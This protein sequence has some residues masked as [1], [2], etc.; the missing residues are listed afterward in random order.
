MVNYPIGGRLVRG[1]CG[2]GRPMAV[3]Q[4]D[5]EG[6]LHYRNRCWKCIRLARATKKDKCSWCGAVFDD[7]KYLHVDH[8]D[9]NPSNNDESNLQTL[10]I[11]C[12]L[13]KTIINKDWEKRVNK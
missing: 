2:C 8:K 13:K 4:R 3:K 12:H 6:R 7:A 10:C 5:N 11:P 9:N 1:F